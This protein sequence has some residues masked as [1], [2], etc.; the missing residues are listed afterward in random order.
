MFTILRFKKACLRNK[1]EKCH[2]TINRQAEECVE[3]HR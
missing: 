1:K 3:A 2:E